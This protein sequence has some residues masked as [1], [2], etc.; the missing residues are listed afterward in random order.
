MTSRE[1]AERL[2]GVLEGDPG[3][4]ISGVADL[5]TAQPHQISFLGNDKYLPQAKVTKAGVLLVSQSLQETFSVPV[6]RVPSASDAFTQA[7]ALFAPPAIRFEAGSHPSA[8][9]GV[10]VSIGEGVSIQPNAVI[11]ADCKIGAGTTIGAGS[12]IGHG[13]VIGDNCFIYP[14]VVIRERSVIGNRV[15]LQSG[16]VIGSDG[17]GYSFQK[18]RHIKIPQ[19][20]YVQIDDDVEVG[21]NATIDRGRFDKTW[22]QEGTKIDN[23]VMIA[24]NVVVGKNSIL[25]AQCGISGS[26]T[27]GNYVT[28][29]GQA[30]L[31][32]HIHVGDQA[33]VTAQSG[34]SKDVPSK[35]VVAGRHAVPLRESLRIEAMIRKLPEFWERLKNLEKKSS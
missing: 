26:T 14:R 28:I 31:V 2:Q 22:I 13:S 32:G 30:G 29:A 7:C 33:T 21:A 19:V 34:I 3:I 35:E 12:Y 16:V 24:H 17:F 23:L 25:V 6:I 8:V 9:I 4:S 18:G 11:E 27:L 10:G 5:K 1:L 15:I 20:G